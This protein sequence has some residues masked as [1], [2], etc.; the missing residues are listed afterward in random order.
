LKPISGDRPSLRLRFRIG[1]AIASAGLV[2]AGLLLTRVQTHRAELDQR[3]LTALHRGSYPEA[4]E[5]L[6]QGA[7]PNYRPLSGMPDRWQ[8]LRDLR[9]LLAGRRNIHEPGDPPLLL[10]RPRLERSRHAAVLPEGEE[11]D[12]R[13]TLESLVRHGADVNAVTAAGLTLVQTAALQSDDTLLQALLDHRASLRAPKGTA[14]PLN[15]AM[16]A[17]MRMLID[18]GADVNSIFIPAVPTSTILSDLESIVTPLSHAVHA[19]DRESVRLLLQR[20]ADPRVCTKISFKPGAPTS[21][22][23]GAVPLLDFCWDEPELRTLFFTRYGSLN[24]RNEAGETLIDE[25]EAS[26]LNKRRKSRLMQDISSRSDGF[27]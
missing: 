6:D 8:L 21:V 26:N 12:R 24:R 2:A 11:Q 23:F 10:C 14:P 19:G 5:L 9:D 15:L 4:R 22:T 17:S 20:G 13:E 7:D 16:G 1:L 3:L 18:H 25:V 27:P